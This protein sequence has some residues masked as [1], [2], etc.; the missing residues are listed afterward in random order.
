VPSSPIK[1]RPL[2]PADCATVRSWIPSADALWQWSGPWDFT[3]PLGIEQLRRD[4]ESTHDRRRVLAAVN[5]PDGALVGHVM[6][7]IQPHHGLGLIGRVLIDPRR[8]G[9][10]LGTALMREVVR[11]GFD[12]VGLHRLQL[13]VYD[14]NAAAI[15]CYQR[16]GFVIEG[17]TR[18][19]TRGSDGRWDGYNM[20]LLED[21]YR[22]QRALAAGAVLIR[23][24]RFAD[25]PSVARLMTELGYPQPPQDA[26]AW[27]AGWSGDPRAIV[28]VAELD[29]S[30]AGVIAAHAVPYLERSGSF[31]RVVA[32][33][34][35]RTRRRAGVGRR[36]LDA[37]EGWAA[38]LGCRDIEVTSR[39][40]R[41]D[42]HAFYRALGFEDACGRSALFR[43]PL[44]V[45]R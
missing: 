28:L 43:R 41:D 10:A 40:S 35:D 37:V 27:L 22:A 11:L 45:A 29:G 2:E 38:D 30:L 12:E 31:V 42:A 20:A 8:R 24:A 19:S 25:G 36:M 33:V 17:R 18:H 16:V 44:G 7:T 4:L 23:P 32:L 6:L 9:G 1:L 5:E 14:F 3:W 13:A 34:V 21:E 26:D 15:A 39:R